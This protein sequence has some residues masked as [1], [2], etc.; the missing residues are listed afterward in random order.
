MNIMWLWI[1]IVVVAMLLT[2]FGCRRSIARGRR[3]LIWFAILGA[4][5]ATLIVLACLAL[6]DGSQVF[7][8]RYWLENE[9]PPLLFPFLI[10]SGLGVMFSLLPASAVVFFYQTK[11][12]R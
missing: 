7:T 4:V 9:G 8:R 2:A 6:S 5:S 11:I 10:L 12:K 1:A 3:P